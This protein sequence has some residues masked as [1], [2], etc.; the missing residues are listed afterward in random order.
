MITQIRIIP[1][2]TCNIRCSYC[3]YRNVDSKFTLSPSSLRKAL[4]QIKERIGPSL[5]IHF[6][7]GE[8]LI[9]PVLLSEYLDVITELSCVNKVSISSNGTLLIDTAMTFIKP[10]CS[11]AFIIVTIDAW[12]ASQYR[13]LDEQAV[14]GRK[15]LEGIFEMRWYKVGIA[16]TLLP[17]LQFSDYKRIISKALE[18]GIRH[19]ELNLAKGFQYAKLNNVAQLLFEIYTYTRRIDKCV[20]YGDWIDYI[21]NGTVYCKRKKNENSESILILP[22]ADIRVCEMDFDDYQK[23]LIQPEKCI[24]PHP[25]IAKI[26]YFLK[27]SLSGLNA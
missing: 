13:F 19:F 6:T 4:I 12:D 14:I 25:Q 18:K 22:T 2:F 23:I 16:T 26:C 7:G 11:E 8:P 24:Y 21:R 5:D 15:I 3:F 20:L 9:N 10:F 1:W 27:D 17:S